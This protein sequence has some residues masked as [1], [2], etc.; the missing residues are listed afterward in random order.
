MGSGLYNLIIHVIRACPLDALGR[1]K[2][3]FL[4][5]LPYC[6]AI[7]TAMT[8]KHHHTGRL[9]ISWELFGELCKRMA[10]EIGGAFEPDCVVGIAKGGLPLATVL[11]SLFRIDCYPIRLSYRENDEPKHEHPQWWVLP[12]KAVSGKKV[13]LV[14]DISISARTLSAAKQKLEEKGT[15]EIRTATLCIHCHSVKPDFF[16]LETDALI[17]HPWD[18]WVLKGG[19]F[20][21]HP[22]YRNEPK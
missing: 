18:K 8:E 10:L 20:E 1:K 19:M 17:I 2:L 12:P 5:R 4:F 22:E 7:H 14:D 21:L 13:L 9:E 11:A 15:R 6:N 16:A 3:D